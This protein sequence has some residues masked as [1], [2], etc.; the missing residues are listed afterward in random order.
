MNNGYYMKEFKLNCKMQM[1]RPWTV[2]QQSMDCRPT[3]HGL[4]ADTKYS[5][6]T[7]RTQ[8]RWTV[9]RQSADSPWTVG[10]LQMQSMDCRATVHGLCPWTVHG[11][12]RRV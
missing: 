12:C 7:A 1:Q 6:W 10:R 4:S 2:G 5:P 8:S 9:G 11:L 3:V